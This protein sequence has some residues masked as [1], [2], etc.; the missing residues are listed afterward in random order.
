GSKTKYHKAGLLLARHR[1]EI[2]SETDTQDGDEI[3]QV[4]FRGYHEATDGYRGTKI[5][6][7]QEG[8]PTA[9]GHPIALQFFPNDG[10]NSEGQLAVHISSNGNVGVKTTSPKANLDVNGDF[11]VD[12]DVTFNGT[13]FSKGEQ[14]LVPR[15]AEILWPSSSDLPFGWFDTTDRL[16]SGASERAILTN[17]LDPAFLFNSGENGALLEG[18]LDRFFQDTDGTTPATVGDTWALWT[19]TS[20]NGNDGSQATAAEQPLL[21]GTDPYYSKFDVDDKFTIPLDANFTGDFCEVNDAGVIFGSFDLGLVGDGTDTVWNPMTAPPS[22]VLDDWYLDSYGQWERW[23]RPNTLVVVDRAITESEKHGLKDRYSSAVTSTPTKSQFAF[24]GRKDI[25]SIDLSHVDWSS[26]EEFSSVFY[27]CPNLASVTLGPPENFASLKKVDSFF[28]GCENLTEIPAVVSTWT[29]VT[30]ATY[31][32]YKCTSLTELPDLSGWTEL[33]DIGGMFHGMTQLTA[34]PDYV[35]T[36]T[37]VTS[38]WQLF[39]DLS[40][41]TSYPDLSGW[42]QIERVDG[43][44]KGNT[45]AT[46][47]FD[48]TGWV[49][50]KWAYQTFYNCSNLT[51]IPDISGWTKNESAQR[52][53]RG[54]SLIE[55]VP[56][57]SGWV[58]VTSVREMFYGCSALTATPDMTGWTLVTNGRTCFRGCSSLTTTPDVSGWTLVED[59]GEMF[60]DC[61]GLTTPPNVSTW[62]SVQKIERMFQN[63]VYTSAVDITNWNPTLL[64][65]ANDFMKGISAAGFDQ[66]AYD[67]TLI[68]WDNAYDL[69]TVNTLSIHFGSAQYTTG[70]QAEAARDKLVAA[71]W[72]ITDRGPAA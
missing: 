62:T 21:E 71:G 58:L 18:E 22:W 45:F 7:I 69:T 47:P 35:A 34:I 10:S 50:V 38:A 48:I 30:N 12:G 46:V 40:N 68:A 6:S 53:F 19:D 4:A 24:H 36:W 1:G 70:G 49:N 5:T 56:D 26:T 65:A 31:L 11:R 32:F 17:L 9:D 42:T 41:L 66:T 23:N 37:K 61:P 3:G 27:S 44:F 29:G 13:T 60:R 8:A 64:T 51:T 59:A 63:A 39:Y 33:T 25:T 54:C 72:T 15:G 67:A 43:M 57:L 20:G 14:Y 16:L 2:D 55:T 28:D 52:L